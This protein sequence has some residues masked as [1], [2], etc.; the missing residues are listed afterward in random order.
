VR[1]GGARKMPAKCDVSHGSA[2]S[3]KSVCYHFG[4][5]ASCLNVPSSYTLIV[6]TGHLPVP[7]GCVSTRLR[8]R[9]R[10]WVQGIYCTQPHM[11]TV[12]DGYGLKRPM[13][14]TEGDGRL[15]FRRRRYYTC[16]CVYVCEQLPGANS[17]LIVTKLRQSYP[18][19]QGTRCLNFG[20]SRSKF[21]GGGEVCALLNAHRVNVSD[22]GS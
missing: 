14:A 12:L 9:S 10:G 5:D 7:A 19:P 3:V 8:R 16:T 18:W 15:S 6:I 11:I 1:C 17:S 21:K 2:R 20:R 4:G 13:M 22:A